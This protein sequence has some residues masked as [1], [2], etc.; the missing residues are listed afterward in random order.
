[1][2][3]HHAIQSFLDSDR[4]ISCF[5]V[6][7]PDLKVLKD[8]VVNLQD[9]YN[10][11]SLNVSEDL[12]KEL[13]SVQTRKRSKFVRWWL[14]NRLSDI[15]EEPAICT[16]IDLLFEPSLK[17]DPLHLLRQIGHRQKIIVLWSGG[18]ENNT[19]S[20]AQPKHAHYATWQN[21]EVDIWCPE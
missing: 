10:C 1:M 18:F 19:L 21:P 5:L 3:L 13:L 6:V 12:S 17:L 8:I 16:N 4:Y 15:E 2:T 11:P 9:E 14:K 20:Y 7:H